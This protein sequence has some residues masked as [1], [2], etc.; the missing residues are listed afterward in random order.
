[1]SKTWVWKSEYLR[2]PLSFYSE[3]VKVV[4]ILTFLAGC[5]STLSMSKIKVKIS[6]TKFLS[7]Y[8]TLE[9][10]LIFFPSIIIVECYRIYE[11]LGLVL[12]NF[13][14]LCLFSLLDT[15]SQTFSVCCQILKISRWFP[16]KL[17]F[18]VAT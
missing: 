12:F 10:V 16:L 14:Y 9:S 15:H 5:R 4:Y 8:K 1:M 3:S 6:E 2:D 13:C 7:F 18:K 11:N 17:F